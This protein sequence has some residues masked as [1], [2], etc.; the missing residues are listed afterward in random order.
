M[1][2]FIIQFALSISIFNVS[3]KTISTNKI[4]LVN[5]ENAMKD[6]KKSG[7]DYQAT[8]ELENKRDRLIKE[9]AEVS[10][11]LDQSKEKNYTTSQDGDV[12]ECDNDKYNCDN[13]IA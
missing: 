8:E 6:N 2:G 11:K 5:T 7:Q 4:F 12:P 10:Q 9:L 13:V 1:R 3:E